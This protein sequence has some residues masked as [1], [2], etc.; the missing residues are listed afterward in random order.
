MTTII[1][2]VASEFRWPDG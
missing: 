2:A 1:A